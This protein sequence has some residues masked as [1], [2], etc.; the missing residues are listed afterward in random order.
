[1]PAVALLLAF[2]A[3]AAERSWAATAPPSTPPPAAAT[4]PVSTTPVSNPGPSSADNEAAARHAKR[5]A[6]INQARSKKLVGAQK[7]AYIK[8]CVGAP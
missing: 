1:M 5:T 2:S 7:T 4:P 6:C 3:L 8:G